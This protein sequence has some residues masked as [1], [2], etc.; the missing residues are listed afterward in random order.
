[1]LPLKYCPTNVFTFL[2]GILVI[3]RE[4][5]DKGYAYFWG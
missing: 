3:P 4:M 2:S 1:M 5:E